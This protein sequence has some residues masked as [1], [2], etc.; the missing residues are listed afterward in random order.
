M[1]DVLKILAG[2]FAVYICMAA[3]AAS[4]SGRVASTSNGGAGLG[5]SG[6]GGDGGG[7]GA[8]GGTGRDA[9]P[10]DALIDALIDPVPAAD[11]APA[12]VRET[13]CSTMD[14]AVAYAVMDYPG[15]T[16]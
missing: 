9:S 14:G 1:R 11:A 10:V 15:K 13:S 2:S 8:M 3:C 6:L 4:D 12:D 5:G 7:G 16:A